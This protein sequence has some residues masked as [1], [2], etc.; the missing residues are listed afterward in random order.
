VVF[1]RPQRRPS[2]RP[3]SDWPDQPRPAADGSRAS[4]TTTVSSAPLRHPDDPCEGDPIERMQRGRRSNPRPGRRAL[5]ALSGTAAGRPARRNTGS[6]RCHR[7][8]ARAASTTTGEPR[9]GRGGLATTIDDRPQA[10]SRGGLD[11]ALLVADRSFG[12]TRFAASRST[13]A[14][15]RPRTSGSTRSLLPASWAPPRRPR[16]ARTLTGEW[17][18]D[19]RAGSGRYAVSLAWFTERLYEEVVDRLV[20]AS[21]RQHGRLEPRP[22]EGELYRRPS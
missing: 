7:R 5:I 20:A 1:E 19:I 18:S 2:R 8:R 6:G 21:M 14:R 15:P 9:S 22:N 4:A 13:K 12:S 3:G 10:R 17:P 16:C 11:H